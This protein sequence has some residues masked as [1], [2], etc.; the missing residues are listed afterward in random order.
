MIKQY[1]LRFY[2]FRLVV[3]LLAISFIGIHLVG[4]AADYLRTR[5]LLG[6]IIGVVF[7]LLLS[8]MD[9]SWLLNFQWIMYGFNIV[10]LLAVRFFG[11]SA[12]AQQDGWILVLFASSRQSYLKSSLSCFLQNFSW[13]TKTI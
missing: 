6:V 1:K 7:M 9:Y 8:L 13:I 11:S 2:N 10:M 12:N 5:Q 3:F 4:T